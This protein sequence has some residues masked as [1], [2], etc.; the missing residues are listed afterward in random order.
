[1]PCC[2]VLRPGVR[3]VV[4]TIHQPRSSI[5]S[6]MFDLLLLSWVVGEGRD[7]A[8]CFGKKCLSSGPASHVCAL[9]IARMLPARWRA[10]R[11]QYPLLPSLAFHQQG[12]RVLLLPC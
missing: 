2:A 9:I 6:G 11:C 7:G 10:W 1:M 4:A 8:S 12:H 5:Y 3:S